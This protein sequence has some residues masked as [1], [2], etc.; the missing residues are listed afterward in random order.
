MHKILIGLLLI[1]A[2]FSAAFY[3]GK[4]QESQLKGSSLSVESCSRFIPTPYALQDRFFS[5]VV[6]GYNNGA[7]V[8]K[9]LQSI[10]SQTYASY[11]LIYIDDAS[12]DGSYDLARDLVYQQGDLAR[13][14]LVRNETRL[15][16]L[17]NVLRAVQSCSDEEIMVIVG[18]DDW[19]A[20]EWVLSRLNQYY[21]NPDLWITYGQYREYPHFGY[22][23][24]RPI[25]E[26][27]IRGQPFTAS[28]LKTFYAGL[29]KQIREQDFAY[30]GI[31]FPAAGEL[32][33]MFPML[34]MA[35]SHS[36]YIDEVLY[37]ANR[38]AQNKEDREATLRCERV[39]RSLNT[40]APLSFLTLQQVV[41][42]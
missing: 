16:H 42:E 24:S 21:A 29:F 41:N 8:Q 32:A 34:E 5:I 35:Q 36:A 4:T 19:L 13:V 31:F 3:L 25:Q 38:T 40:Y 14:T 33:Y 20:H 37:I 18:G 12:D 28:H 22:G 30:Q 11:R 27:K 23:Y 7:Y 10:F 17:A 39:I 6:V 15:G 2:A 26:G 9:T 1:G